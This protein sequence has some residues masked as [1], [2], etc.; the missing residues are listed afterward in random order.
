MANQ[1]D[2]SKGGP[3]NTNLPKPFEKGEQSNGRPIIIDT[4]TPKTKDRPN[5]DRQRGS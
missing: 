5:P 3:P 2:R 4:G 1:D